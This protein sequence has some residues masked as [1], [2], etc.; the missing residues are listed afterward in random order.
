MNIELPTQSGL[1]FLS[2]I[3]KSLAKISTLSFLSFSYDDAPNR[4]CNSTFSATELGF[5][6]GSTV[7]LL[8]LDNCDFGGA[9]KDALEGSI[10]N[11][12]SILRCCL[13]SVRGT[14]QMG[15]TMKFG[16]V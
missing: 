10:K 7:V 14:G 15:M 4:Q 3:E 5:L 11:W 16:S 2:P 13:G 6:S 8:L 12:P 9:K 1:A